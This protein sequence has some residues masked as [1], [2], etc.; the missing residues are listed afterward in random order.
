MQHQVT[1]TAAAV[2]APAICQVTAP[3]QRRGSINNVE[4]VICMLI[5]EAAADIYG[6]SFFTAPIP[7]Q[8]LNI[9]S[10]IRIV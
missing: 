5:L 2:A 10:Q 6:A 8:Y 4:V 7:I 9:Q 1:K 3:L